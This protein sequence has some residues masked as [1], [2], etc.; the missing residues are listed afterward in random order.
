MTVTWLCVAL[1]A[2]TLRGAEATVSATTMRSCVMLAEP[3]VWVAFVIFATTE[4]VS[5]AWNG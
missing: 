2:A 3:C 5:A 4:Y 1:V